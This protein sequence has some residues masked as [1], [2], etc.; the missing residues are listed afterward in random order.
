MPAFNNYPN[1]GGH[2]SEFKD[3][4]L[5]VRTEQTPPSTESILLLGTA[6][7]GPIME[8]VAVDPATVGMVFGSSTNSNGIPN[9]STLVKG[10][11]EAHAAGCRDIRLMRVTG[12]PAKLSASAAKFTSRNELTKTQNLGAAPGN[13]ETVLELNVYTVVDGSVVVSAGGLDLADSAFLLTQGDE[14]AGNYATVTL[15]ENV[16]DQNASVYVSYDYVDTNGDTQSVTENG[17]FQ[18]GD[19]QY[20]VAL[21]Q[22]VTYT[23]TDVPKADSLRVYSGG[24][25]LPSEAFEM[26]TASVDPAFVLKPGHVSFGDPLEAYFIHVEEIEETPSLDFESVFGGSVYNQTKLTISDITNASAEVVGKKITLEKPNAKKSQISEA[27][28]EYS[29]LDYPTLGILA[30]AIIDDSRNNITKVTLA[31]RYQSVSSHTLVAMPQTSFQGGHDGLN[32]SKEALFEL[33]GGKRDSE[34]FLVETGAYHLLENYTVDMI[35]PL[36][37][38]ADDDLPGRYDNFAYQLA[39]ACAVIS[40]RNSATV[41]VIAT[42]S[43]DEVSLTKVQAHEQRLLT[44]KNDFYMRDRSGAILKDSEGNN[45]DLGRFITILAGPDINFNSQRLGRYA[46]NSAPAAAGFVSNL[47]AQSSPANKVLPFRNGLRYRYSNPQLDR[48]TGARYMTFKT[49]NNGTQIAVTDAPTAAQPTSDYRRLTTIR[50]VKETIN[51]LRQVCDP[52]IGEPNETAQRNA[53]SAAISKRL[54]LLKEN[55]VIVDYEFNIVVTPQMQLMGE[56]QIELT[57]VPP[58]ELRQITTVV[59]L[60]PSL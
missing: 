34:G 20:W 21:G 3:G 49:K 58:Q 27:P 48:L 14:V 19:I 36:G 5:Q 2:L 44:Y 42:S 9:G 46:S 54:E 47:P 15:Y 25:E 1:L 41:G 24:V 6:V 39:L 30:Q 51:N 12:K 10:F 45:I 37:V 23:L 22:D 11:E 59:T 4:G 18:A 17:F 57:L 33:L 32:L 56:A 31:N 29:S 28:L 13:I 38:Y 43:P 35:I 60:R 53:M 16:T 52:Y 40:H 50:V 8:P 26:S 55:G 7:D